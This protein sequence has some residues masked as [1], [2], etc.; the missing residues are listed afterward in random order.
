MQKQRIP[1]KLEKLGMKFCL[2][3]LCFFLMAA[4]HAIEV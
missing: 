3:Q 4:E 2:R 1:F